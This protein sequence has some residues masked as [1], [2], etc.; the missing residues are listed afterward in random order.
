MEPKETQED[1]TDLAV[2]ELCEYEPGHVTILI[3]CP[4]CFACGLAFL[5]GLGMGLLLALIV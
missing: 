5:A 2:E 4:E 3:K 1:E